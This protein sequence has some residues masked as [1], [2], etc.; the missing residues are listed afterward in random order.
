[1]VVFSTN[2]GDIT[3]ELFPEH[4]RL[5][6]EVITGETFNATELPTPTE[7]EREAPEV[8]TGKRADQEALFSND[9]EE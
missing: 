9:H 1:M 5:L 4:E 7:D 8:G 3:L 2:Y 6:K